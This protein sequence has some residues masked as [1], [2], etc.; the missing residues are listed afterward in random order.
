MGIS[1]SGVGKVY[2]D[3]VAFMATKGDILTKDTNAQMLNIGTSG[4]LLRAGAGGLPE[5]ATISTPLYTLVATQ[6][7]GAD[8]QY[9][10]FASL[11]L[12]TAGTYMLILNGYNLSGSSMPCSVVCNEDTTAGNYITQ[13]D[14]SLVTTMSTTRSN[15]AIIGTYTDGAYIYLRMY[16]TLL[17]DGHALIRGTGTDIDGT[18]LTIQDFTTYYET[19]ANITRIRLGY[20]TDANRKWEVG[21]KASLYK[22][23]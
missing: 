6:T 10:D 23:V 18:V 3:N 21:T 22:V 11:D 13:I 12:S 5:W 16:I 20:N 8:A 17:L 7:L 1:S 19:A 4:Q 14:K 2:L 15:D 9:I